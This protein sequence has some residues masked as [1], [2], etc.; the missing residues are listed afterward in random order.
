MEMAKLNRMAF[1]VGYRYDPEYTAVHGLSGEFP[2]RGLDQMHHDLN[3]IAKEL[4]GGKLMKIVR[5]QN[6]V[7]CLEKENA[8]LCGL[9]EPGGSKLHTTARNITHALPRVQE[10]YHSPSNPLTLMQIIPSSPIPSPQFG[11]ASS[12]HATGD[13]NG[14]GVTSWV[15]VSSSPPRAGILKK[16]K[17]KNSQ[18]HSEDGDEEG[19]PAVIASGRRNLP[20]Q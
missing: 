14:A 6:N 16:V 4:N 8:R 13:A 5:L 12:P 7:A 19:E 15:T 2:H 18:S 3:E 9:P 10:A 11:V 1:T 20:E 17:L